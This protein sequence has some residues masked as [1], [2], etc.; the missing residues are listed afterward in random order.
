MTSKHF[1]LVTLGSWKIGTVNGSI[2]Q[3]DRVSVCARIRYHGSV[4]LRSSTYRKRSFDCVYKRGCL[5]LMKHVSKFLGASTSVE[6]G[7]NDEIDNDEKKNTI[8]ED[9]DKSDLE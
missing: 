1:A 6:I 7:N 2:Q 3:Q 4:Y 5:L 8:N 9:A